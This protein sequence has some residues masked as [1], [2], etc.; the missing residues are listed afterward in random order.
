MKTYMTQPISPSRLTL[1]TG[2]PISGHTCVVGAAINGAVDDVRAV[3]C[4]GAD[5]DG[6]FMGITPATKGAFWDFYAW[7]PP[8]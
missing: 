2:G 1:P 4:N 8:I 5:R 6:I 3:A 7:S